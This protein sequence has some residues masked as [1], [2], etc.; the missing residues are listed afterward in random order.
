MYR[1]RPKQDVQP[2]PAYATCADFCEIFAKALQPVYLLT[3]MLTGSHTEAEQCFVASIKDVIRAN[4]VFKGW[5]RTWRIIN[6]IRRVF[7]EPAESGAKPDATITAM[8]S[9]LRSQSPEWMEVS[10]ASAASLRAPLLFSVRHDECKAPSPSP[11]YL[12]VRV[13]TEAS[14]KTTSAA[15]PASRR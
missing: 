3:F 8:R 15:M 1:F 14:G 13:S 12:Q 6:T 4:S 2:H 9:V 11:V 5:E 10:D 7:S